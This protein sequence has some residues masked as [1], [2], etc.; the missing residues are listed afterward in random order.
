MGT[1]VGH[2]PVVDNLST[3]NNM[4]DGSKTRGRS[5]A[6]RAPALQVAEAKR[7]AFTR[8]RRWVTSAVPGII[9]SSATPWHAPES[10]DSRVDGMK[11]YPAGRVAEGVG[12]L[13]P[14]DQLRLG[15]VDVLPWGAAFPSGCR[16]LTPYQRV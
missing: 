13:P 6:G 1:V 15:G 14:T 5:S 11:P 10:P 16:S 7:R 3:R 12:W 9:S 8:F 4:P 2:L